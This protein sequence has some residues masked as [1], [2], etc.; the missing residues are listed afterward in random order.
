MRGLHPPVSR[1][2]CPAVDA[3][4]L[5]RGQRKPTLDGGFAHT[6]LEGS[7][8]LRRKEGSREETVR[9]VSGSG[10]RW[11]GCGDWG[12]PPSEAGDWASG[13]SQLGI[14]WGNEKSN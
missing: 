13:D 5:P 1:D 7:G 10:S 12:F 6:G 9:G 11:A 3:G 4:R 2:G 14:G 8:R